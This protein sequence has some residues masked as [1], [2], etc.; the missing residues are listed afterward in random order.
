[1]GLRVSHR[2]RVARSNGSYPAS[3]I[4]GILCTSR[5]LFRSP[6][7]YTFT[8]SASA[9]SSSPAGANSNSETQSPLI[10]YLVAIQSDENTLGYRSV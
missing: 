5:C 10:T 7:Y 9:L 8:A 4:V 6:G 3:L 2:S 1:M